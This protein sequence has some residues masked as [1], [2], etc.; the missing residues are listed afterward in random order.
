MEKI[1]FFSGLFNAV[2]STIFGLFIFLKDRK[3][4]V[5]ITFSL[6][7]L[8]VAF[9]SYAYMIWPFFLSKESVLI[10]F[11]LLHIG[12]SFTSITYLHFVT[13]WLNIDK[14]NKKII[15]SGY[16]LAI[17]F[18]IFSFSPLF[19]SD[20][21]PKFSMEYWANPGIIYHFYL[22]YFFGYFL[23]SSILL[24]LNF[25]RVTGVKRT[26]I[27]YIL[28]GMIIAFMGG[29]T[30]YPLWY[31]INFPPYGNFFVAFYV[32]LTTYAIIRYRFMDIKFILR[33]SSVY[34]LSLIVIFGLA[35]GVKILAEKFFEEFS[36]WIDLM[37]IFLA[38]STFPSIKNQFFKWANEYFF[39]SLYDSGKLILKTGNDL[40]TFLNIDKIYE[41]LF[42]IFS[43][44]LHTKAFSVL[45]YSE[46]GNN[47]L[48]QYNKGFKVNSES[49]FD[50]NPLVEDRFI[51][52]N[53]I[54]I[55]EEL[56]N[57]YYNEETK[58]LVDLLER[59]EVEL[60]IP[61]KVK[62]NLVGLLALGQKE[63]GEA[64]NDEDLQVLEIIAGQAAVAIENAQLYSEAK[65]FNIHLKKEVKKA[66]E[67]VER[68]N[69][70]L[71]KTNKK[72]KDAYERLKQLDSA[73]N[74]F[75]SIASHQLRTPLTSIKGFISMIREGDYGKIDKETDEAL[76]KIFISNERLIKLVNDLLSLSRIESGKFGFI[77]KQNEIGP[78]VKSIVDNFKIEAEDKGLK[79]KYQKSKKAITPFVFDKDKIHEVVSNLIDNAIKYT[80]KGEVAVSLESFD[81][82]IKITV[83]DTGKGME[84]DE[85]D[86][87]FEKFRRGIESS[88]LNTEGVGLGLYVCRK[89]VDAHKG[90]IHAESDGLGK[91]SRFIVEL[92]KDLK[93]EDG[94]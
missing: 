4:K 94:K 68:V 3:N 25:R 50:R 42:A 47:Y 2:I 62:G 30:N 80:N 6:F 83:S 16:F 89:I 71:S 60:L 44:N 86:Y 84:V 41:Y 38:V 21:V 74:E 36:F 10:S 91:G 67:N 24:F 61:L 54:V 15:L 81:D 57:L 32:I 8:S 46:K 18:S 77:F 63:T 7:C 88:N 1:F 59:L 31:D 69:K 26:Q 28:I 49:E 34:L 76:R 90:K 56:R 52:N 12:A 92:R 43:K 13:S 51:A 79:V 23:Y 33:S 22:I 66:T 78:L 85:A 70:D 17:L 9:W 5:N 11:Q 93:L 64:Y 82:K 65:R 35:S 55:T 87:V 39:T 73:K 45:T 29:S 72:L 20:V 40:K 27:K 48:L 19:I 75:I 58:D 14:R 37:V 53:E